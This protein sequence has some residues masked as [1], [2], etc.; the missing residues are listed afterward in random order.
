ME[1]NARQNTS[2]LVFVRTKLCCGYFC[3][4]VY[5]CVHV[6]FY[7]TNGYRCFGIP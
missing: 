6:H 3:L 4:F 2:S 1:T 7:M 5:V